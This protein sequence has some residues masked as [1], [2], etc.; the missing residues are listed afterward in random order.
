[1]SVPLAKVKVKFNSSQQFVISLLSLIS[2]ST[3]VTVSM[4]VVSISISVVI[5]I[6]KLATSA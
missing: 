4:R 1:M 3:A 2:F 6:V 5:V